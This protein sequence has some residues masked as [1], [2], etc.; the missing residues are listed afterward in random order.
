MTTKKII[1]NITA[2]VLIIAFGVV[3]AKY[4]LS[5]A[6]QAQKQKRQITGT[7]VEVVQIKPSSQEVILPVIGTIEA[8]Q[9]TTIVSKV[10]G[11]II[12]THP[13]FALGSFVKKGELLAQIDPVDYQSTVDEIKAKLLS[14]KASEMIEM[15]QQ[16]SA[17]KELELSKEN[18]TGLS[19]AL[20]LR[21]PQLA[22]VKAT[23]MELEAS[24]ASALNNLKETSIKAPYDGVIITKSAELG[25]YVSTQSTL[26]ELVS[27]DEFWM[28]VTLPVSYL[29]FLDTTDAKALSHIKVTLLS[30][31][32]QPLHVKA[33]LLKILPDLDST[34]KQAKL[35]IGVHDPFGLKESTKEK[36][37]LLLAE[38]LQATIAGKRFDAIYALPASLLR[39]NN[40]VWVMDE[41]KTLAI[42]PVEVLYKNPQHVLITS[43]ITESDHI[44]STYLTA[45]IS[46]MNLVNLATVSK[47]KKG[48]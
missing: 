25:S 42:K 23:I 47:P 46:G 32:N 15:G 13:N 33:N 24:Y 19:R 41:N 7:I 29:K 31:T 12:Q 39:P 27:T 30:N 10:S 26:L 8:S 6:P 1:I 21:E 45:P 5:T 37:A 16:E 20:I 18:P 38:T 40:T 3:T 14:A 22:Q 11:K 48:E 2:S 43:G 4:L 9:K 28:R 17:K 35:L 44:I 34:T 36:H